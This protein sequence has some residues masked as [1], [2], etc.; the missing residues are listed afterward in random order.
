MGTKLLRELS[1][2][3]GSVE[4]MFKQIGISV[5]VLFIRTEMRDSKEIAEFYVAAGFPLRGRRLSRQRFISLRSCPRADF[6]VSL[7][8]YLM[9]SWGKP[10]NHLSPQALWYALAT[11][12]FPFLKL[13][14]IRLY[15]GRQID[16][17]YLQVR[18]QK[19]ASS[20]CRCIAD[21]VDA[22]LLSKR[23]WRVR[24]EHGRMLHKEISA[25]TALWC[26]LEMTYDMH[27]WASL[28][29]KYD[30]WVTNSTL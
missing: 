16:V 7:M 10:S 1:S 6:A 13:E 26:E 15:D 3:R 23:A 8:S 11:D 18:L 9:N 28:V 21:V 27:M 2:I 12:N 17:S 29:A 19:S 4:G 24:C 30:V 5:K 20:L 22:I 14:P 25:F